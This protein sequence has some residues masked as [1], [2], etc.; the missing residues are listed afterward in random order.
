MKEQYAPSTMQFSTTFKF[1]HRPEGSLKI[2]PEVEQASD[3]LKY[4]IALD[5]SNAKVIVCV[6]IIMY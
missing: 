1:K 5:P 2:Q 6:Y 4:L 3:N